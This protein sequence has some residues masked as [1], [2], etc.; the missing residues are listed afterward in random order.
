MFGKKAV[1]R[2]CHVLSCRSEMEENDFCAIFIVT[3]FTAT[4]IVT[5]TGSIVQLYL[6]TTPPPPP[7]PQRDEV[8]VPLKSI[9]ISQ[10]FLLQ[11]VMER[12]SVQRALASVKGQEQWPTLRSIL[13]S[14]A[15]IDLTEILLV[16]P[17]RTTISFPLWL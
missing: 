16:Q 6:Y 12:S 9:H 1:T 10:Y 7:P 13:T 3:T 17:S 4:K 8:A 2:G 15:A 5:N 11:L 14:E